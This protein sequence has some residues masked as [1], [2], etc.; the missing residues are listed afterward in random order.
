MIKKRKIINDM[1]IRLVVELN[2]RN[3]TKSKIDFLT[4]QADEITQ[5]ISD[6]NLRNE[7]N[8]KI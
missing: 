3:I 5:K 7:D 2:S 1:C 8:W 4:Y 6:I